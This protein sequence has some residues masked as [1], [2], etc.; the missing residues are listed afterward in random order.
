VF[1]TLVVLIK[2]NSLF[3]AIIASGKRILIGYII[4]IIIGSLFGLLISRV[5]YIERNMK[6]LIV[7]LQTL[8]NICW[9][10]FAVLWYGLND[11]AIIFIIAIGSTFAI[12]IS[13][14]SAI[15]NINPTYL[16]AA[17][18]LRI[19]GIKNYIHVIIPAALPEVISGLKQG[20]SFAWRALIAGEMMATT[21][22][23]GQI[24]MMGRDLADISQV[25]A[26]M[27]VII[28]MGLIV[29]KLFFEQIEIRIRRKWG[30]I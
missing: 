10:P 9:L 15:K 19:K 13:I 29:D 4:S 14:E 26:I 21:L 17:H 23:L 20:W 7:G 16:K 1:N 22:G 8:P 25:V 3:I 2:D 5:K 24:L 6:S 28:M 12:T 11:N 18:T 30:L 27:I